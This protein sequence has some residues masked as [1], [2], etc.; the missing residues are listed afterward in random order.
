[1]VKRE[2]AQKL[3]REGYNCCQSVFGAFAD[4]L[5]LTKEKAMKIASPFGAGFGKLR[6]VCGAVTGMCMVA[7]YMKGYTNPTDKEGKIATY[8]LVQDMC[9]EFK[10]EQGSYICREMLK[11]KPGEDLPEPAVRDEN[12]YKSRPCLSACALAAN[13]ATKYIFK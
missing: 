5:G 10:K 2:L 4:E 1:M 7:G 12:Y 3:F 9:N 8:K 6:E 13:I 11:L